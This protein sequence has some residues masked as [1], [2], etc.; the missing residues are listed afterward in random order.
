MGPHAAA[1]RFRAVGLAAACVVVAGGLG[2]C[3]SG[4]N[5]DDLPSDIASAKS[6]ITAEQAQ[7]VLDAKKLGATMT[8]STLNDDLETGTTTCW[9]LKNGGVQLSQLAVDDDEKPLDNTGDALRTKQL[10]AAGV[11]AFCTD[12][13]DQISQLNLP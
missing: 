2:A 1:R 3:S 10:M 6:D 11:Q 8:A 9:A 5:L 12:Y 7:F 4:P 13:A